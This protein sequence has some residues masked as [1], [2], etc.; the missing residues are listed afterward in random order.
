MSMPLFAPSFA[1]AARRAARLALALLV[2]G[3]TLQSRADAALDPTLPGYWT[4]PSLAAANG[5]KL[6]VGRFN[7]M[8]AVFANADPNTVTSDIWYMDMTYDTSNATDPY[9][10]TENQLTFDGLSSSPALAVDGSGLAVVVW[11]TRPT[12]AS[13]LGAIY[14]ARQT[15]LNCP[16][17][18]SPP[19][20][21]VSLGDEPSIATERGTVHVAWT[22][23]DRVQYTSF[24]AAAPPASPLWLGEVADS[25]NCPATRFHQPSIALAHPPCSPVSVRIAALLTADEQAT[26]GS[27]HSASTQSGPRVYERDASTQVW[28]TVFQEVTSDPASNQAMPVATSISLSA[29]RLTGDFYLAWSDQQNLA[30]RTRVGHGKGTAWDVSQLIDSQSHHVHVAARGSVYAGQFRLAVA[31]PAWSTGAYTQT[32]KWNGTLSWTGPAINLPDT[33]YP[34]V[35]HPQALYWSRCA[36]NQ[37]REVRTFTEASLWNSGGYTEMA[38]DPSLA[39]PV[40]CHVGAPIGIPFP[41]CFPTAIL[42]AQ[43]LP[44]GGS[45]GGV[46]VDFGDTAVLTKLTSTGAEL[47]TLSGAVIQVTWSPGDV[48]YSW[49]TG[50]AVATSRSSLQFTSKDARFTVEDVGGKGGAG[51]R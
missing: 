6:S 11:V 44:A 14:Y 32:G 23:G 43:M 1:A 19:K 15:T 31:G 16:T 45:S 22:S 34:L 41:N 8:H 4:Q 24:P 46:V 17:C 5:N 40:N 30:S 47:T 39:S 33:A 25:T 7:H 50:F 3:L 48:L 27:C 20:Q 35:G 49:E 2:G 18:W 36:G 9:L 51:A 26:A 42:I 13:S 28:S 38:I 10:W 37:L 21:I 12:L 29:S